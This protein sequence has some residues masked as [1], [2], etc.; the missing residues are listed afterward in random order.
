M[1]Q[2][3]D[4]H[5]LYQSSL[6]AASLSRAPAEGV[7]GREYFLPT[8]ILVICVWESS[9]QITTAFIPH[10]DFL[11]ASPEEMG[12]KSPCGLKKDI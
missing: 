9:S 5:V 6:E 11:M 3:G 10:L 1:A 7:E 8:K 2:L 4:S 12:M